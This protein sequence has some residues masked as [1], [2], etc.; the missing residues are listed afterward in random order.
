MIE[1]IGCGKFLAPRSNFVLKTLALE[2]TVLAVQYA[3]ADLPRLQTNCGK[4][5]SKMEEKSVVERRK[6]VSES[7][8]RCDKR[9]DL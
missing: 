2:E 3:L 5:K 8:W 9:L 4:W 6:G 7:A 1:A